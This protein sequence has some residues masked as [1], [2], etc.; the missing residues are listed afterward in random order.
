MTIFWSLFTHTNILFLFFRFPESFFEE[1][2]Y[3]LLEYTHTE[4]NIKLLKDIV[5][6]MHK[7]D[8]V[9]EDY[10]E[11]IKEESDDNKKWFDDNHQ[12]ILEWLNSKGFQGTE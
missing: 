3:Q 6:I 4:Q 10:V 7:Q 2:T 12:N 9:D 8:H 5:D 1:I 11:T